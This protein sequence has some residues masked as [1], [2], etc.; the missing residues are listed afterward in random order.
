M[1]YV[2]DG[3]FVALVRF[4][5]ANYELTSN[6][7]EVGLLAPMTMSRLLLCGNEAFSKEARLVVRY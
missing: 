3:Y 6:Y 2:L 7:I 4:S 5:A 1:A